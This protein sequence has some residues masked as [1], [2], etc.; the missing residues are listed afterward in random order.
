MRNTNQTLRWLLS[1]A[2]ALAGLVLLVAPAAAVPP[3]QGTGTPAATV[4]ATVAA[5]AATAVA[6]A[7]A[8][9]AATPAATAAA[10]TAAGAAGAAQATVRPAGTATPAA[11][12]T[13]G[14]NA[15]MS[16]SWLALLGLA[17]VIL[18]MMTVLYRRPT[19]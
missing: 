11:L 7:V 12:P 14:D 16:G 15:G 3:A 13:T 1:A 9:R 6:T 18:G 2:L 17:L 5:P 10:T 19:A 4:A 8:T